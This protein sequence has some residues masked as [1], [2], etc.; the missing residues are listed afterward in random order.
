M[1]IYV[2]ITGIFLMMAWLT[3]SFI[4]A[5]LKEEIGKAVVFNIIIYSFSVLGMGKLSQCTLGLS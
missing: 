3:S 4:V 2:A 5:V 1:L